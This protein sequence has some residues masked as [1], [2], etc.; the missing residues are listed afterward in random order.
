MIFIDSKYTRWYYNI[1]TKA[2]SRPS[3]VGYTEKHHII[4]KSLGGN[5]SSLNLV[6]LT[7]KEHFVCHRLLTK[8]VSGDEEKIKMHNAVFQMS[9][10]SSNQQR[11]KITSRTY[12]ILKKN[13][14]A[15]MKGN[16]YGR[17]PMSEETKRKISESKKGKS[18]NKGRVVSEETKKKLSLAL[19]DRVPWNL[20]ISC[21][22][23]WKHNISL[24][25][26]KIKQIKCEYCYKLF[27]P[28]NYKRWHG[29]NC[30]FCCTN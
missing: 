25:R 3:L 14:S 27:S 29:A 7:P 16:Q 28:S 2:V 9:V 11:Y 8:M 19:K 1:I 24:A 18:V 21:S 13:K 6:R 4:P 20:G 26:Q 17:R 15:S 5:N 30:K 23:E 22:E 12:E 10:Q